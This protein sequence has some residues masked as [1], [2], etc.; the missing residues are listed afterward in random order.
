M[1]YRGDG[2]ALTLTHR[3]A[4]PFASLLVTARCYPGARDVFRRGTAA[5]RSGRTALLPI[6]AFY[7]LFTVIPLRT[8]H[9][10]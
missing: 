3:P 6:V 7:R 2:T 4:A 9:T 10:G 8:R 5:R 1:P